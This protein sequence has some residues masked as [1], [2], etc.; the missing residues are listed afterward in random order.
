MVYSSRFPAS[1]SEEKYSLTF[2][3]F[4]PPSGSPSTSSS[5]G[6]PVRISRL[7]FSGFCCSMSAALCRVYSDTYSVSRFV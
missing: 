1:L 2:S 7:A 6:S 5:N 4:S 3:A